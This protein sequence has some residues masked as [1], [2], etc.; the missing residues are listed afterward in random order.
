MLLLIIDMLC[1][2][3]H[4]LSLLD[5]LQL[6]NLKFNTCSKSYLLVN[7]AFPLHFIE[8]LFVKWLYLNGPNS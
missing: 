6:F 1:F 8:Q 4:A 7:I 5:L 3:V 2:I